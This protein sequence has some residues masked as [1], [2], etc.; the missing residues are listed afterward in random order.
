[1]DTSTDIR[2]HVQDLY[3]EGVICSYLLQPLGMQD[4]TPSCNADSLMMM[5]MIM[6][7]PDSAACFGKDTVYIMDISGL[8]A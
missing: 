4:E 8:W 1:M 2:N 7:I 6:M 5:M 3:L